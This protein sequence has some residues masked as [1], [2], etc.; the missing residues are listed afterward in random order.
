[1][2]DTDAEPD[3]LRSDARQTLLGQGHLAMSSGGGVASQRLGVAKIDEALDELQR[4]VERTPAVES[5]PHA[6]RHQRTGATLEILLCQRIIA[7]FREPDIVDPRHHGMIA[8]ELRH[9]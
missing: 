9:S 6:E 3:G 1:M 5:T 4:I 2:L 8:Q 7:V